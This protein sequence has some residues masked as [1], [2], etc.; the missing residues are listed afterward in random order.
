MASSYVN[1]HFD[2][3]IADLNFDNLIGGPLGAVVSA[4]ASS[5]MESMNFIDEV[6][7]ELFEGE[8]RPVMTSF[9]Y[10]RLATD[11]EGKYKMRSHL[12][13]VPLLSIVPIPFIQF[14]DVWLNFNVSLS[15]VEE[16]KSDVKNTFDA[17]GSLS[18][19]RLNISGSISSIR[20]RKSTGK[21]TRNYDMN[22][23]LHAVQDDMP[24]GME[25][26]LN[27]LE[28]VATAE[29]RPYNAI[30]EIDSAPQTADVEF[31]RDSTESGTLSVQ[32]IGNRT[33]GGGYGPQS[34]SYTAIPLGHSTTGTGSK[35]ATVNV[36]VDA[37]GKIK[38]NSND[39][40]NYVT[41]V[42]GGEDYSDGDV[43]FI[44]R[45][46][47][48]D[49]ITGNNATVKV[50]G[51]DSAGKI[52]ALGP[53]GGSGSGNNY[54]SDGDGIYNDV[55]LT[56]G[57]GTGATAH[58]TI[59][60]STGEVKTVTAFAGT[61]TGYKVGDVLSADPNRLGG[62]NGGGFSVEV[63][64]VHTNVSYHDTTFICH[65]SGGS[66]TECTARVTVSASDTISIEIVDGGRDYLK[67]DELT[68]TNTSGPGSISGVRV[69][70]VG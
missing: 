48:P 17:A 32:T 2:T 54:S 39:I 65:A 47:F 56:G 16:R 37:E 36:V 26:V 41:L 13:Q 31:N 62:G 14:S 46:H 20:N 55:S 44:D 30:L 70:K 60:T 8:I 22:I 3:E 57:S 9:E 67:E 69:T 53:P 52:L 40:Q 15:S 29:V 35:M 7:L 19:G 50:D 45:T 24:E 58:I 10:Q 63:L 21:L 11:T 12:L 5:A 27:I 61:G 51:V 68:L 18:W 28:Q 1:P 33:D 34:K 4:Q 42:D 25:R 23:D 43:L 49:S 38:T 66:G 64:T 6:G 59:D